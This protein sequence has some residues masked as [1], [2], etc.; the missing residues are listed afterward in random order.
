MIPAASS[1]RRTQ[2]RVGI[3]WP[4]SDASRLPDGDAGHVDALSWWPVVYPLR[5]NL[6]QTHYTHLRPTGELAVESALFVFGPPE[7]FT[8]HFRLH[9]LNPAEA[10][11]L[12]GELLTDRLIE[13]EAVA[14]NY[15]P[16][17]AAQD[18]GAVVT[19]Q[20]I[21]AHASVVR[22]WGL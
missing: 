11:L 22:S 14:M 7:L 17:L 18:N 9:G 4:W 19:R 15:D 12:K 21:E 10:W 16:I 20:A 13:D 2:K 8:G 3:L 1:S 5:G 6:G